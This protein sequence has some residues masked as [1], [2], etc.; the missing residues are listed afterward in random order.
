VRRSETWNFRLT[1]AA[2][3]TMSRRIV[4]IEVNDT[5]KTVSP[6][7]SFDESDVRRVD[8]QTGEILAGFDRFPTSL[9]HNQ[10]PQLADIVL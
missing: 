4:A 5:G 2:A 10:C 6:R 9:P 3:T 8:P 1:I 7:M